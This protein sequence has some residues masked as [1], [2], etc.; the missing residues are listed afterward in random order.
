TLD[1]GVESVW[2]MSLHSQMVEASVKVQDYNYR[3]APANLLGEV[4]SQQKNSTTYGTDYR[5]DE[6]YKGLN[7]NGSNTND[8]NNHN[9]NHDD[10]N[11]GDN[12]REI[13]S[14]FGNASHTDNGNAGKVGD[15]V[16]S[17]ESGEW[18]ARI[19]HEQA[20]SRQILIRGKS[21]QA[22]LAPGQHIRIKGS[23][24]TGIDE[25]IMIL[26]VQ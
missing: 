22:N 15:S 24:I 10:E 13:S 20:I 2:D 1:N 26:T 21:N 18:Y 6:H 12:S 23:T 16:D 25:G 8:I 11:S 3:D 5:Y 7:S 14:N 4:N 17:V 19:R 9:R